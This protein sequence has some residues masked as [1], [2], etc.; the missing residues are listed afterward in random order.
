MESNIIIYIAK[1]TL[2]KNKEGGLYLDDAE[3]IASEMGICVK[4]ANE[5]YNTLELNESKIF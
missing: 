2:L 4:V 3:S 5:I 1:L